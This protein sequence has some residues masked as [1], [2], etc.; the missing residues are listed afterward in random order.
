MEDES[1]SS[2]P[3]LQGLKIKIDLCSCSVDIGC[4]F[5]SFGCITYGLNFKIVCL[6]PSRCAVSCVIDPNYSFVSLKQ[7]AE[8]DL[9]RR[10]L[11]FK[12]RATPATVNTSMD[13]A[14]SAKAESAERFLGLAFRIETC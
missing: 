6:I 14:S 1:I 10:S 2:Q 7:N 9:G 5:R 3:F 8:E 4:F 13:G 11:L 12:R